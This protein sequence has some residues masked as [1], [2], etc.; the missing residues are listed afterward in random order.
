MRKRRLVP[1]PILVEVEDRAAPAGI[2]L[3]AHPSSQAA[4]S[5]GFQK[6]CRI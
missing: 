3:H 6:S 4:R 5:G 2:F 1:A